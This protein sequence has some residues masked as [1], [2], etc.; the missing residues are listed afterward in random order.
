MQCQGKSRRWR[1]GDFR[2]HEASARV[3]C[4]L[5]RFRT[6]CGSDGTGVAGSFA[7]AVPERSGSMFTRPAALPSWCPQFR[8]GSIGRGVGG[9]DDREHFLGGSREPL[10]C[11]PPHP[12]GLC[13][14]SLEIMFALSPDLLCTAHSAA[15][16]A[17][18]VASVPGPRAT[19]TAGR[20]AQI[21]HPARAATGRA[22]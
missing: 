4:A 3:F 17:F 16:R 19:A 14:R 13:R 11:R 7:S 18:G 21:K 5:A 1:Y 8:N 6:R 2:R 20:M 10:V 12:L 9:F 22:D 15:H